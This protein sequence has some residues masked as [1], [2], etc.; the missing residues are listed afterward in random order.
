VT[1]SI[2]VLRLAAAGLLAISLSGCISVLPKTKPSQLYRFGVSSAEASK[3]PVAPARAE[4]IGVFRAGGQ[5]QRESAGDRL[6]TIT[7]ERAS[8]IA[9]TRWVAPAEVLFDAAVATAFEAAP[10]VR[11]VTR[12][13]PGRAQMSLRLDMRNFETR[14]DEAKTPVV[15]VRVRAVLVRDRSTGAVAEHIFETRV[16]AERNRVSAIVEAYNTAIAQV[17]G[18]VVAWT[19]SSA[20]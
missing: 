19:S 1:R 3:T 20:A 8:Y 6:L 7:G 17:L 16:P 12:G 5:F 10:N 18:E 11:L 2:P 14:Y 4:A 13:E 15:L 9:Q